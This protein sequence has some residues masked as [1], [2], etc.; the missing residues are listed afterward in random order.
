MRIKR[1]KVHIKLD[2][3]LPLPDRGAPGYCRRGLDVGR[4]KQTLRGNLR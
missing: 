1:S 2:E 3:V 4:M